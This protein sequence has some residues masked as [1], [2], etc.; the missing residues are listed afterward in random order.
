VLALPMLVMGI[1]LLVT[2]G[3]LVLGPVNKA[4]GRLQAPTRFQLNDF[5][6]LLVQLQL[7]LGFCVRMVEEGE[8]APFVILLG[9]LTLAT[10]A[11]WAGAVSFVSKAGVTDGWRRGVFV[12]VQLPATLALMM[13]T[14]VFFAVALVL[15]LKYF[16]DV[17]DG[18]RILEPQLIFVG[19]LQ[20]IGISLTLVISG[21][22]LRRLSLWILAGSRLPTALSDVV[23]AEVVES[24]APTS[25]RN[26]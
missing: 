16:G 13:G 26:P 25:L 15:P 12:L 1:V 18:N 8:L 19:A 7:A 23:N 21:W 10:I 4:A 6:W 22:L 3:N 2:I 9:F 20:L 5:F 17:V 24:P 14:P 11:M